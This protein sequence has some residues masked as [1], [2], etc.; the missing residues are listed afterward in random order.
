MPNNP[1]LHIYNKECFEDH[2]RFAIESFV[3]TQPYKKVFQNKTRSRHHIYDSH[4]NKRPF[5]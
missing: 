2:Q 4:R 3:F 5:R 1:Q